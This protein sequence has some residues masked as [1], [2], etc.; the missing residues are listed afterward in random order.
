MRTYCTRLNKNSRGPFSS[1]WSGAGG[2]GDMTKITVWNI[3]N[4][5]E[6]V[7]C[8]I[9]PFNYG[10]R[11]DTPLL[12]HLFSLCI[13]RRFSETTVT[14]FSGGMWSNLFYAGFVRVVM[15]C[16]TRA[17][18]SRRT[19]CNPKSLH[20]AIS[21]CTAPHSVRATLACLLPEQAWRFWQNGYFESPRYFL[22]LA[23][24][25]GHCARVCLRT[26]TARWLW[27]WKRTQ[28]V[29][30]FGLAAIFGRYE[31]CTAVQLWL[32]CRSPSGI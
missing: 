8:L 11:Y 28:K 6:A 23:K 10:W 19:L 1:H 30:Q 12:L 14:I 9:K 3:I 18:G 29:T 20:P 13:W 24:E 4:A 7:I 21:K 25:W 16:W 22:A 2:W 31:S 32:P 27:S 15:V 5:N 17:K 26:R